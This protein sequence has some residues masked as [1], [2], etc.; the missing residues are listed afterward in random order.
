MIHPISYCCVRCKKELNTNA[1]YGIQNGVELRGVGG[2]GSAHDDKI[3][4][5]VICDEC[6][7][8]LSKGR[9]KSH[10]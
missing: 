8:C 3:I 7:S 4:E 1:D 2:Y 6:I 5:Y 10:V 9:R